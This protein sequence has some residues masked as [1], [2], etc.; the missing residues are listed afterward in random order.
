MNTHRAFE[1]ACSS[2]S[3][4]FGAATAARPP[5]VDPGAHSS[6][7]L[8][9]PQ[10]LAIEFIYCTT[11][12]PA[13]QGPCPSSPDPASTS[14]LMGLANGPT[15][16]PTQ[17]AAW[18]PHSSLQQDGRAGASNSTPPSQS[19]GPREHANPTSSSRQSFYLTSSASPCGMTVS[20]VRTSWSSS[21]TMPHAPR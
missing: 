16:V 2:P 17:H 3:S 18:A 15:T 1:V 5:S 19:R 7:P 10:R 21:T 9:P 8:Q 20:A 14:G 6:T 11:S 12:S 13:R 4:N